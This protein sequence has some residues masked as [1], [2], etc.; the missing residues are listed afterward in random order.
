MRFDCVV[1]PAVTTLAGVRFD[2]EALHF[3]SFF[4]FF[5]AC[6]SSH[7]SARLP[8]LPFHNVEGE[9][10]LQPC[11]VRHRV[12]RSTHTGRGKCIPLL[13]NASGNYLC[14]CL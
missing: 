12:R 5:Y 6:I 13:E 10:G 3:L 4:F 9:A 7:A 1:P 2:H 8:H 14:L 11:F